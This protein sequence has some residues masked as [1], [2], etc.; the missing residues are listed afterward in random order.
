MK[1]LMILLAKAMPEDFL[2]EK[3][4]D[5]INEFLLI[6]NE[7]KKEEIQMNI[8]LWLTKQ[9]TDTPEKEKEINQEFDAFLKFKKLHDD[10]N[11]PKS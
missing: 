5:S 8:M 2:L 9:N 11:K 1:D 3:I 6:K 4:R 7:E 10:I